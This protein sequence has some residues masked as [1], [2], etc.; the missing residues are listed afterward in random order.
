MNT[1]HVAPCV[2]YARHPIDRMTDMRAPLRL[3]LAAATAAA[4]V[5]LVAS[6][7][8]AAARTIPATDAMY[9]ISCDDIGGEEVL[10]GVDSTSAAVTQIG[11]GVSEDSGCAG[12]PA[13]D[14][15]TNTAYYLSFF[16]NEHLRSI[17]LTTGESTIIGDFHEGGGGLRDVDAIAIGLDGSAYALEGGDFFTLDLLTA[18]ITYVGPTVS[19]VWGF[20]VD[21]TSGLLYGVTEDGEVYSIANDGTA[22]YNNTVVL[23]TDN[24]VLSLQID[25]AGTFWYLNSLDPTTLWSST[26][27]FAGT[28]ELSGPTDTETDTVFSEALLIAPYTLIPEVVPAALPNMGSEA[29]SA[30]LVGGAS[31]LL[32]LGVVLVVR[33]GRTA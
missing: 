26:T 17:N 5:V 23:G 10:F 16:P 27:D 20:A 12:Q 29:P 13:W 6:P 32:L 4:L 19:H 18:E 8:A 2:D 30:L 25:S 9:I 28:E 14:A 33:R 22:V 7:A 15:T 1:S 31:L 24:N 21:P 3:T 11:T